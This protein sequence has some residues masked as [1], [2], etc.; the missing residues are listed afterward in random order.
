M[1]EVELSHCYPVTDRFKKLSGLIE[2]SILIEDHYISLLIIH[3][4]PIKDHQAKSTH[5]RIIYEFLLDL[6]L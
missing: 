6:S 1:D 3:A 4:L 2:L 5:L